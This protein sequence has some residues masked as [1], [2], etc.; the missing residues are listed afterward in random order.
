MPY[1]LGPHLSVAKFIARCCLEHGCVLVTQ[2]VVIDG[3]DSGSRR[4][5]MRHAEDGRYHADLLGLADDDR[6]TPSSLR[7]LC[8]KLV[9]RA[10]DFG[11]TLG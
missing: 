1:P 3:V 6:L 4:V 9:V 5:L 11:Y 7:T 8:C 10:Q 2:P